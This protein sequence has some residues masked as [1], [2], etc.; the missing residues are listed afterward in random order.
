MS[1]PEVFFKIGAAWTKHVETFSGIGIDSLQHNW[2]GI[3]LL[4]P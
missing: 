1:H 2:N 3:R 4:P